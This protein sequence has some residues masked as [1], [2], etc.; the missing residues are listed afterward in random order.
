M[1]SFGIDGEGRDTAAVNRAVADK[2]DPP[3]GRQVNLRA[4]DCRFE[5]FIFN[6]TLIVRTALQSIGDPAVH[7]ADLTAMDVIGWNLAGSSPSPTSAPAPTNDPEANEGPEPPSLT[8]GATSVHV[9]RYKIST[10]DGREQYEVWIDE[11][12]IPVMFNITDSDGTTT[13]TLVR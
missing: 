5:E 3:R 9:H 8:I 1:P 6:C 13:F 10:A 12:R 4:F 7:Q 11:Q 2:E